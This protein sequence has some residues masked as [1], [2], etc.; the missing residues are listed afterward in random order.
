MLQEKIE[1]I[2]NQSETNQWFNEMVSNLRVDQLLL[3]VDVL[4]LRNKWVRPFL[5]STKDRFQRFCKAI[6]IG[7]LA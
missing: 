3:Q 1:N 5:L 2:E 6:F 7:M 4:E